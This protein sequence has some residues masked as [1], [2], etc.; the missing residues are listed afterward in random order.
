M[1]DEHEFDVDAAAALLVPWKLKLTIDGKKYTTRAPS[2]AEV[3]A[4]QGLERMPIQEAADLVGGLIVD[5]PKLSERNIGYFQLVAMKLMK[6]FEE[7]M[8]KN[9][10]GAA[11]ILNPTAA[12]APTNSNS[13]SGS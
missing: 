8:R 2:I 4:L 6:Y 3:T 9:S 13:T 1:N 11:A 5:G 7:H 10:Q 12:A